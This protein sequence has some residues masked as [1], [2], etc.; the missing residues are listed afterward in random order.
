[1]MLRRRWRR[2]RRSCRVKIED[3]DEMG[4]REFGVWS[5]GASWM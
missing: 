4:E 3:D 5:V 1:L 2:L